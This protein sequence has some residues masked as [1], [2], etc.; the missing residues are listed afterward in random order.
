MEASLNKPKRNARNFHGVGVHV[1]EGENT[2]EV[3]ISSKTHSS[4]QTKLRT[5]IEIS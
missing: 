5:S 1:N 3:S 4:A 2:D